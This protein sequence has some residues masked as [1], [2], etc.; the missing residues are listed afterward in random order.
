[1]SDLLPYDIY[2]ENTAGERLVLSELPFV[3]TGGQLFDAKWSL[4]TVTRQL[5]EGARLLSAKRSAEEKSM[6]VRVA[7]ENASELS[8]L[9][10]RMSEIFDRDIGALTPGRLWVNDQYMTCWCS[11]RQKE[12]SCDFTASAVVTVSVLP[13][14]PVWCRERS[15]MMN[16]RNESAAGGKSYPYSYPCRYG[17]TVNA[18]SVENTACGECPVRIIF[19]GPAENPSVYINGDQIGVYASAEDGEYI[20]IDQKNREISKVMM[21]GERVNCFDL[22]IK[23]GLTFRGVPAGKSTVHTENA[24]EVELVVIEQRSEPEWTLN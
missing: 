1:V 20:I 9:L 5:G 16:T 19:R 8:V 18:M 24:G 11:A 12:L 14:N 13:E 10:R 6:T 17:S 15:F 2:Y 22:R 7:A 21:N 23:N 4:N 3:V